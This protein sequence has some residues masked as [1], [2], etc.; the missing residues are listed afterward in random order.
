MRSR[1]HRLAAL[2][3]TAVALLVVG[4]K[5][6]TLYHH[7]EHTATTGWE[8]NDTLFF[9]V[10][11]AQQGEELSEE[12]EL[13]TNSSYPFLG[14]SLIVV[15]TTFPSNV[16]QKDTL[17][18]TLAD[19]DGNIQGKGVNY[20]QHHFHLKDFYTNQ[21]DSIVIAIHHNMK[22]ETLPGIVDVGV[23]LIKH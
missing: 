4:C 18:C 5:Q 21:G 6:K 20:Y 15:Q 23:K 10:P 14:V 9:H 13:R 17:F 2:L 19:E 16:S 22:R 11:A 8:K 1:S 7:Y 3:L 12:V